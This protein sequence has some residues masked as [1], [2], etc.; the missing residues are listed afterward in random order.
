MFK[1][2]NKK[3]K[4]I[5]YNNNFKIEFSTPRIT[6]SN[7][8]CYIKTEKEIKYFYY[9][10]K[11]YKKVKKYKEEKTIEKWKLLINK[12]I[13]DFP[14]IFMF[15]N[16]LNELLNTDPRQDGQKN[17][18]TSGDIRYVLDY[19]TQGFIYEDFYKV[20]KD[21]NSKGKDDQY[22]VYIG[23]SICE[24]SKDTLG[25]KINYIKKE[26]I[27]N[28]LDGLNTFIENAIEDYNEYVDK[29]NKIGI[30]SF[31]ITE[32]K[33]Y[34]YKIEYDNDIYLDKTQI[35][36]I[37]TKGD[38]YN[39]IICLSNE[40]KIKEYNKVK[41]LEINQDNIVISDNIK[42]PIDKLIYIF[43]NVSDEKLKYNKDEILKDFLKILNEEEIKEFKN[44]DIEKLYHKY[45]NCI[46]NRTWM[47]RDEHNL[48]MIINKETP[49]YNKKNVQEIVKSIIKDIQ[50][51]L[52]RKEN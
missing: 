18:Y 44:N 20:S 13:Y 7:E 11:I 15:K 51:Q 24:T 32:N 21:V 9:K 5:W 40:N 1:S 43:N 45:N 37:Y 52:N 16:I 46:I 23:I 49:D 47:Y 33:L 3:D 48:P 26:E 17:I 35:D 34:Q 14:A 36:Y 30:E 29:Q 8:Y 50:N 6:T 2:K 38:E 42:I 25:V 31:Y 19:E 12:D 22:S 27:L 4:F 41:I 10:L 28:L 39:N